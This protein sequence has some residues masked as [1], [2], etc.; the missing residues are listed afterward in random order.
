MSREAAVGVQTDADRP[1]SDGKVVQE[2]VLLVGEESSDERG[3][4]AVTR[5]CQHDFTGNRRDGSHVFDL[6]GDLLLEERSL[7]PHETIGAEEGL[8]RAR[9]AR[10]QNEIAR[11]K[12]VKLSDI[13][14]ITTTTAHRVVLAAL[15]RLRFIA[16]LFVLLEFR[17]NAAI[18]VVHS[19][20]SVLEHRP[21][22]LVVAEGHSG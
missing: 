6:L 1:G 9:S 7:D 21:H 12:R 2:F 18:L 17:H 5:H 19:P 11:A 4:K 8:Y 13:V 14:S 20:L 3:R 16:H 22:L 15:A 10:C